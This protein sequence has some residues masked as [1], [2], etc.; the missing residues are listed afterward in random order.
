MFKEPD[1]ILKTHIGLNC[2]II[3]LK[4]LNNNSWML[5]YSSSSN[6][7]FVFHSYARFV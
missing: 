1:F 2:S 5:M 6:F 7:L 3:F 4:K